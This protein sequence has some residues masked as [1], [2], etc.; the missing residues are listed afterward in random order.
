MWKKKEI[1]KVEDKTG[2]KGGG[3]VK[4]ME[5]GEIYNLNINS[6]S[7]GLPHVGRKKTKVEEGSIRVN[8]D[9]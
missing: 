2:I 3:K 6:F 8:S 5:K 1:K 4:Q 9:G 7:M